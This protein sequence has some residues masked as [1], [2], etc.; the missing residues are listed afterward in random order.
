MKP[1][2][3]V[4]LLC[5]TMLHFCRGLHW[6]TVFS[7]FWPSQVWN[8]PGIPD[9]VDQ[10]I[11]SPLWS[12][13][14]SGFTT[15][16]QESE[17]VRGSTFLAL[18]QS[19]PCRHRHDKQQI[20]WRQ[21]LGPWQLIWDFASELCRLL[22]TSFPDSSPVLNGRASRHPEKQPGLS[23]YVLL[24]YSAKTTLLYFWARD[25]LKIVCALVWPNR[26]LDSLDDCIPTKSSSHNNGLHQQ[27]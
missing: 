9:K 15:A 25:M 6:N 7:L 17:D 11:L 12:H 5:F 16:S 26:T 4:G 2:E 20:T 3:P 21:C 18:L 10:S 19:H 24:I 13:V 1:T 22:P 23:S 27:D 8:A 14:L